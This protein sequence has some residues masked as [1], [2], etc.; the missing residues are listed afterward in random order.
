MVDSMFSWVTSGLVA[1]GCEEASGKIGGEPSA[2]W[3]VV[4]GRVDEVR[5]AVVA[6]LSFAEVVCPEEEEDSLPPPAPHEVARTTK[7]AKAEQKTILFEFVLWRITI[8]RRSLY[9]SAL[10]DCC[11]MKARPTSKVCEIHPE[12]QLAPTA[13]GGTRS[14]GSSGAAMSPGAPSILRLRLGRATR[15]LVSTTPSAQWASISPLPNCSS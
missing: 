13:S 3:G 10:E 15:P 11:P 2:A 7:T 5:S 4:P 8:L 12:S 9:A 1:P 6:L 14:G